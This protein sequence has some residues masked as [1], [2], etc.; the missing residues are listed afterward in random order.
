MAGFKFQTSKF[1]FPIS[2]END[3][4]IKTYVI[5]IGN[6]SFLRSILTKGKEVIDDVSSNEN[7]IDASK[8]TLK[9]FVDLVFGEGEFNFLYEKFGQNL[10]AMIELVRAISKEIEAKWKNRVSVYE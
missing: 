1:S 3:N 9:S 8:K 6:E 10:F 4:E 7:D 2:D 5:D